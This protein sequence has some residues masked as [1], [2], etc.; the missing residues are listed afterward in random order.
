MPIEGILTILALESL[1]RKLAE[2][3]EH[4]VSHLMIV[5]LGNN[6]RPPYEVFKQIDAMAAWFAA[7]KR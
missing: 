5:G 7:Q 6:E 3:L 1:V 4:P 2:R